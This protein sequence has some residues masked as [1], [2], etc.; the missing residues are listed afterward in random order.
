MLPR[1]RRVPRFY[2]FL[3]FLN[4]SP[5]G[6]LP[7]VQAGE[8]DFPRDF[9][10]TRGFTLGRPTGAKPAPDGKAVYFLRARG[11]RDARQE[12][13]EF[14]VRTG[15]CLSLPEARPLRRFE[16]VVEG[17]VVSVRLPDVTT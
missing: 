13:C 9:A 5:V 10:A 15:E 8:D 17:D 6:T 16:V 12:L 3:L 2:V 14:D 4:C 11:P 1:F 7:G